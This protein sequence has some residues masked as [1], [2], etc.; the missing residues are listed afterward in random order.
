MGIL[1]PSWWYF[2]WWI[3][4]AFSHFFQQIWFGS[5]FCLILE[6]Q[7]QVVSLVHLFGKSFSSPLL[8]GNIYHWCWV[9]FLLYGRRMCFVFES[10][11]LV[12]YFLKRNFII[13]FLT[14]MFLPVCPPSLKLMF[15][16]SYMLMMVSDM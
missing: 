3:W 14:W 7:Y 6:W 15:V 4:S 9:V 12:C 16:C 11:M 10:I 1:I 13:F 5:L 2:T 8:G